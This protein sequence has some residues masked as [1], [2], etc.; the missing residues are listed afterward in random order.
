MASVYNW[1]LGRGMSYPHQEAHSQLQFA[2]V[3]N[4][5]RCIACQTCTMAC[6]STW[7]FAKGQ[8]Y[9]WWNNVESKPYGGYPH[10][11]DAK[12]L[13]MLEAENPDGQVWRTKRKTPE[14]PYGEF[15]GKTI[16]EAASNHRSEGGSMRALGYVPPD[17]E[18][19][20]PNIHEETAAGKIRE[21]DQWGDS[22]E[23]PEHRVWFFYLQRLCNHCTYPACL[24]ACP[25]NAIYKRPEDGI[26]LIDQ[27]R[28]RGYR[29]C[30]EA[31][32]YKKPMYNSTTRI[33]E[34]CIACYPRIE[35]KDGVLSPDGAPLETRCMAA[36]VGKIRLQGLVKKTADGK[37]AK[38]PDNPINFL[39]RERKVALPLYPQFGTEPNGYYI[40]PRWVPR[41]Y[42]VQMFGP[43]VGDALD[44]YCCPDRELLSVLQLFRTTQQIIFK[45]RI[46]KGRKVA[47]VESTLPSGKSAVQEI[48]NDTVIGYNKSGREVTRITVE[49]PTFERSKNHVNSI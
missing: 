23:L 8:E 6:K 39:V 28:C 14:S 29:K 45:F 19:R 15:K 27:E 43:G 25:R 41:S 22:V 16:F 46:E 11:W 9:M 18:W 33:S 3:F 1:Q 44:Q 5:N 24:A 21:K 37:W 10:N 49:E 38:D 35:G 4:I 40:P 32:P 48:F 7:T 2:F 47:E 30:V 20:S 13:A 31:C 12:L 34:K 17:E 36:C 42:L 26:V